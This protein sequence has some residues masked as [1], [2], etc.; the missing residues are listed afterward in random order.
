MVGIFYFVYCISCLLMC[1]RHSYEEQR[2]PTRSKLYVESEKW[3]WQIK[4]EKKKTKDW[5]EFVQSIAQ[6]HQGKIMEKML[7]SFSCIYYIV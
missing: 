5:V 1:S 6:L 2:D 7:I 3:E 4:K